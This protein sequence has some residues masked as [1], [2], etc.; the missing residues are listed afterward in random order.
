MDAGDVGEG[1]KKGGVREGWE[2]LFALNK[3]TTP[4]QI[5]YFLKAFK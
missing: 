4:P 1:M 3:D 5:S 2:S